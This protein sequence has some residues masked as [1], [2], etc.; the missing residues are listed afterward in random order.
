MT[1]TRISKE[2]FFSTYVKRARPSRCAEVQALCDLPIPGGMQMPCRWK[3]SG[4]GVCHGASVLAHAAKAN[5]FAVK[6]YCQDGVLHVWKE[7]KPS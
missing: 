3:H 2:E 4:R 5:G 1:F 7:A 6:T